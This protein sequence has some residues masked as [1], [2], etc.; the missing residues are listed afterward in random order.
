MNQLLSPVQLELL[1][2]NGLCIRVAQDIDAESILKLIFTILGEFKLP[3]EPKG[4]DADLYAIESNY[5][6]NGGILWV[7]ETFQG[8][9]IATSAI[10][11]L[12]PGKHAELRKMYIEEGYR[13]LGLGRLLMELTLSWC[14][15]Q[16][17]RKI[18]LETASV[19][20]SAIA[21]YQHFGFIE[22]PVKNNA[23]R[24]DRHFEMLLPLS[25]VYS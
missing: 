14:Q 8:K 25:P 23:V 16:N 17:L 3:L 18:S 4:I 15:Q 21:M 22:V 9:I 1:A 19:L 13:K 2:S 20:K 24:C 10:A 7:I 6:K 5:H 12:V 11:M